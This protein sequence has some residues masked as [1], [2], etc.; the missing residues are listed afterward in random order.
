MNAPNRR[1]TSPSPPELDAARLRARGRNA[2][3]AIITIEPQLDELNGPELR[4]VVGILEWMAG[5]P[6]GGAK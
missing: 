1:R 6:T 5:L 2:I 4:F 3:A